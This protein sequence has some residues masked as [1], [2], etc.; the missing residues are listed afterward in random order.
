[1]NIW[2]IADTHFSHKRLIEAGYRHSNFEDK[3]RK[4]LSKIPI[5][6]VLIHLG[7]ICLGNDIENNKFITNLPCKKILVKGNHDKGN[8]FYYNMGWDFVCKSFT[9]TYCG[10]RI[11]FSHEPVKGNFDINIHGHLHQNFRYPEL[12][13]IITEKHF[14]VSME[15]LNYR[16][17]SLKEIIKNVAPSNIE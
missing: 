2:C 3:L 5:G 9:D 7:D 11:K 6:D 1:M 10:K 8:Q 13:Y 14:L 16:P 17:V 4:S 15:E 12:K